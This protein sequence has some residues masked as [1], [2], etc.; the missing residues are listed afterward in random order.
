[1]LLPRCPSSSEHAQRKRRLDSTLPLSARREIEAIVLARPE[2]SQV[3]ILDQEDPAGERY[4]IVYATAS[5]ARPDPTLAQP[6]S[7]QQEGRV[8]QWKTIFNMTYR[9]QREDNGPNFVG[10]RSS[11]TNKP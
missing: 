11:Y 8:G 5:S 10:W 9:P 2:V 1:M 4:S 6:S 7:S 3:S